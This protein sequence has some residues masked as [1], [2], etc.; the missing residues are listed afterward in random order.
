MIGDQ[1]LKTRKFNKKYVGNKKYMGFWGWSEDGNLK[2]GW[3]R[4][5][6]PCGMNVHIELKVVLVFSM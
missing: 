3:D 4:I 2:N 5:I 6:T 1:P